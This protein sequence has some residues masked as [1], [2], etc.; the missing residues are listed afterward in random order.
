MS[1]AATVEGTVAAAFGAWLMDQV[2]TDLE[3][4]VSASSALGQLEVHPVTRQAASSVA[5]VWEDPAQV[6]LASEVAKK[7]EQVELVV[8]EVVG[9]RAYAGGF[10]FVR[11]GCARPQ[12]MEVVGVLAAQVVL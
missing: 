9:V 3:R 1:D 10:G 6:S 7:E 8:Q 12:E 5:V 4:S 2:L 11:P